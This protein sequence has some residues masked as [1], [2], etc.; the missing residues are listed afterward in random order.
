MSVSSEA[1]LDIPPLDHSW[2]VSTGNCGFVTVGLRLLAFSTI[3][4]L[5]VRNGIAVLLMTM[6]GHKPIPADSADPNF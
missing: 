6:I 4:A 5:G 2:K 3:N 1:D